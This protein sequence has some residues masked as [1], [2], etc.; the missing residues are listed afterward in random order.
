LRPAA[1][2]EAGT[3]PATIDDPAILDEIGAAMKEKGVEGSTFFRLV[4]FVS[5]IHAFM[6]RSA[7]SS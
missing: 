3:A 6:E 5:A 4:E 1:D 7:S 2:G